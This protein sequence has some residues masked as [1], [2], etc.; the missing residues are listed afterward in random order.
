[1]TNSF[2]RQIFSAPVSFSGSG[3][4][5]LVAGVPGGAIS[6][7]KILLVV[8]GATNITFQDGSTNLSGAMPISANGSFVLDLDLFGWYLSSIGNPINLNSSNAVQ[9]SGTVYYQLFP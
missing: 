8:A 1:M 9:V 6:I 4:N 7:V 3:Q 2:S 5:A